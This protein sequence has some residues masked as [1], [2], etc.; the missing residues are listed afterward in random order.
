MDYVT[1]DLHFGHTRIISFER[2][3]FK[4]IG[5]HDEYIVRSLNSF[6]KPDD[7]LYILGDVGF[8]TNGSY[9]Y[10]SSLVRRIECGKKILVY[11]NHDRFN[12]DVAK[13]MG[14]DEIHKGPMYYETGLT[15]GGIILS[16]EP[17]K[18]ALDNPYVANVH[19]HIHNGK[20][21]LG[22][23]KNVNIAETN[24]RPMCLSAFEKEMAAKLKGRRETFG[25][26]WYYEYYDL[27]KAGAKK[28]ERIG[29]ESK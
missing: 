12:S 21:K 9:D 3:Q 24:Y 19:G 2:T 28:D 6:L 4:T 27:H 11:G 18:E 8:Q 29:E 10:I 22:N 13:N 25:R 23:Y 7:T 5:E 14:F 16:H 1:A 20:L 17:V 15:Q 26:E